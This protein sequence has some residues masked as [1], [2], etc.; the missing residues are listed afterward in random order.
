MANKNKSYQLSD[1]R[2]NAGV[3]QGLI[4]LP[5]KISSNGLTN[6][7]LINAFDIDWTGYKIGDEPI[8]YTGELIE[9]LQT[10]IANGQ[11]WDNT[12]DYI[13]FSIEVSIYKADDE[14]PEIIDIDDLNAYIEEQQN[15]NSNFDPETVFSTGYNGWVTSKQP[16]GNDGDD[17][18]QSSIVALYKYYTKQTETHDIG[19]IEFNAWSEPIATPIML[20][21]ENIGIQGN[22]KSTCFTRT[23]TDISN[24]TVTGGEYSNGLPNKTFDENDVELTGNNKITWED[25]IPNGEETL[26]SVTG[27]FLGADPNNPTW[28]NNGHPTRVMDSA[29]YDV[30]FAFEIEGHPNQVPDEPV[31]DQT[32]QYWNTNGSPNQIWYDPI[33]D[34]NHLP[35][36]KNWSDMVWRAEQITVNGVKGAWVITRIKGEEG[37]AGKK[38]NF[39]STVFT[40]TNDDISGYT[41]LGG[42]YNEPYPE[43]T[44]DGSDEVDI[45]WSDG[46]PSGT[47]ILWSTYHT[48]IVDDSNAIEWSAP[49]IV[50]DT[51]TYDV[52][53]SDKEE[54]GDPTNNPTNWYDPTDDLL[55]V[56]W[57]TMIW[58]AER[59]R[60]SQLDTWGP[61]VITRIKGENGI[62][63]QPS[64]Y[65]EQRWRNYPVGQT[66]SVPGNETV[67][68]IDTNNDWKLIQ[69]SP[70]A[71]NSM[72]MTTR[73]CEYY[74]PNGQSQW[75]P[76]YV[77]GSTW[78]AP[79]KVSGTD[80]QSNPIHP[81]LKYAWLPYRTWQQEW[82]TYLTTDNSSHELTA[83]DAS[84]NPIWNEQPGNPTTTNKYLWMVQGARY[85]GA[86]VEI[87][88][89]VYWTTPICLS[90]NDGQAGVDGS[91][92]EFIYH[93]TNSIINYT[94]VNDNTNP[95][96]WYNENVVFD[97]TQT[98]TNHASDY[99]MSG[100]GW[101]DNPTGISITN[102][103]EYA[104]YRQ[105]VTIGATK[106]W[107]P[108]CKPFAW[109]V[110]GETGLDGDG[111]EYIYATS[112]NINTKPTKPTCT[113]AEQFNASQTTFEWGVDSE[114]W[115]DDPQ[116]I[117]NTTET[118]Q[119]VSTRKF[120]T[121][122][123]TNYSQLCN[124][125]TL[126]QDNTIT[127]NGDALQDKDGHNLK[128]GMKAWFPYSTP[129]LWNWYV[130]D[131]TP[132]PEIVM[133]YTRTNS[134]T[135]APTKPTRSNGVTTLV[136]SSADG[137]A[138]NPG[139]AT[140]GHEFLW[141]SSN[142]YTSR[143]NNNGTITYSVTKTWADPICLTGE[144]G[145]EGVDGADIE[146][147]YF[148]TANDNAQNLFTGN[149][150]PS[151]WI[152]NENYQENDFPFIGTQNTNYYV[153]DGVKALTNQNHD[154][155]TDNPLGITNIYDYEYCSI[156]SKARNGDWG[157]FCPPFLWSKYGEQGIDGDGIEYIYYRSLDNNEVTFGVNDSINPVTWFNNGISSDY[158]TDDEYTPNNSH[159]TDDPTGVSHDY[160]YEYVS[161]RKFKTLTS[162]NINEVNLHVDNDNITL[163]NISNEESGYKLGD[164]MWFPYS[165]PA[166]WSKYADDAVAIN[167]TLESDNDMTAVSVTEEHIVRDAC[168]SQSVFTLYHNTSVVNV[169]NYSMSI[170]GSNSDTLFV[171]DTV[172]NQ[173]KLR[174]NDT[175][176]AA[177]TLDSNTHKYTLQINVPQNLDMS[178]IQ[179]ELRISVVATITN[180]SFD[181]TGNVSVGDE[182]PLTIKVKGLQLNLSD[183]YQLQLSKNALTLDANGDVQPIKIYLKS[184]T[185]NNRITSSTDALANKLYVFLEKHYINTD[186]SDN[187]ISGYHTVK[188]GTNVTPL[189]A[190]S[191]GQILTHTFQLYYDV[192]ETYKSDIQ[193]NL[194]GSV[195]SPV[196]VLLDEE[197]ISF[198]FDGVNGNAGTDSKSQEYVYRL[199]NDNNYTFTGNDN[200][201]NWYAATGNYQTD[202]YPFIGD[203]GANVISQSQWTDNPQSVSE[204]ARYEWVS[205]REYNTSTKKWGEFSEPTIWSTWS[206]DGVDGDGIEYIF[207]KFDASHPVTFY[208]ANNTHNPATWFNYN[209]NESSETEKY[210]TSEY[211]HSSE[212]SLW[213]DNA[214]DIADLQ[215]GE[216]I[217]VSIRKYRTIHDTNKSELTDFMS[218]TDYA[219]GDKIWFPYSTPKLWSKI[220]ESIQGN[221]GGSGV[222]VDFDNDNLQLAVNSDNTIKGDNITETGIHIYDDS[223]E[224]PITSVVIN[225]VSGDNTTYF[226]YSQWGTNGVNRYKSST[227]ST[228]VGN[229][230]FGYLYG[231]TTDN[232]TSYY[233]KIRT[234]D[235]FGNDDKI[236]LEEQGKRVQFKISYN[237]VDHFK[238]LTIS[239]LHYGIDGAPAETFELDVPK[240]IHYDTN[241]T[242][243]PS[244]IKGL[245]RHRKGGIEPVNETQQFNSSF[246]ISYTEGIKTSTGWQTPQTTTQGTSAIY[247][248]IPNDGSIAYVTWKLLDINHSNS[249]IDEE[250][251]YAVYDG[252]NGRDS[253]SDEYIYYLTTDEQSLWN[254]DVNPSQWTTYHGSNTDYN[255]KLIN[256]ITDFPFSVVGNQSYLG[257]TDNP[258]GV[259]G[260]N[261]V[262]YYAH[263]SYDYANNHWN[264]FDGPHIWSK[265]GKDGRDGDGV[266]YIFKLFDTETPTFS[267]DYMNPNTYVWFTNSKYQTAF[268]YT[269]TD[270]NTDTLWRDDPQSVSDGTKYQFVSTRRYRVLNETSYNAY[271]GNQ[272]NIKNYVKYEGDKLS[273]RKKA[274]STTWYEIAKKDDK[275]WFPYSAPSLWS[276]FGETGGQGI[277]GN[278]YEQRYAIVSGTGSPSAPSNSITVGVDDTTWKLT[279]TESSIPQGSRV[280]MTFRE[281]EYTSLTNK[282]YKTGS[283]WATPI[284]MTGLDGV[285]STITVDADNDV[286]TVKTLN[287][288]T[289]AKTW[290]YSYMYM[291]DNATPIS[292]TMTAPTGFTS[293]SNAANVNSFSSSA[294]FKDSNKYY[295]KTYINAD[296]N[297]SSDLTYSFTCKT[298][299]DGNEISRQGTI[300]VIGL[301]VPTIYEL[302]VT[303]NVVRLDPQGDLASNSSLTVKVSYIKD[304]VYKEITTISELNN[305]SL[306]W[307]VNN[308]PQTNSMSYNVS[309]KLATSPFVFDLKWK[310][311]SNK[312]V[313]MDSETVE[314]VSDGTIGVD[315]KSAEYIYYRSQ[316]AITSWSGNNDP[317]TWS[318]NTRYNEDDFPFVGAGG[319]NIITNC[320]WTDNPQGIDGSTYFYEYV[321]VREY[322]TTTKTWGAF[323]P[324]YP[325]STWGHSGLDGDGIEYIFL[326]SKIPINWSNSWD[327]GYSATGGYVPTNINDFNDIETNSS[328][329]VPAEI[330]PRNW[331][332][333]Y[334]NSV[335]QVTDFTGPTITVSTNT[336]GWNDNPNEVGNEYK[337]QYVSQRKYGKYNNNGEYVGS[338][339]TKQWGPFSKPKLWNEYIKGDDGSDAFV[340]EYTNDQVNIAVSS[341]HVIT[342]HN[343]IGEYS[344]TDIYGVERDNPTSL[345]IV[346]ENDNLVFSQNNIS[347]LVDDS[348]E[349]YETRFT[350]DENE[351]LRTALDM[352]NRYHIYI[353]YL[354]SNNRK[355]INITSIKMLY[356]CT[357]P[358]RGL[359]VYISAKV[360]NN[361]T[362]TDVDVVKA[363]KVCGQHIPSNGVNGN[364][365]I[366]YEIVPSCTAITY[367][368]GSTPSPSSIS[369]SVMRYNGNEITNLSS[370]SG[371]GLT[372]ESYLGHS[373]LQS[374]FDDKPHS[375][376]GSAANSYSYIQYNL[377]YDSTI[378]DC[379]TVPIVKNGVDGTGTQGF[380][381]S[382]VRYRGQFVSGG[383]YYNGVI[384]Q[385]ATTSPTIYYKDIV[386]ATDGKYY[387]P[388]DANTDYDTSG[389]FLNVCYVVQGAPPQSA[390]GGTNPTWKEATQFDF[391]A[392]RL[393]YADQALI[394]QISSHDFI[395]TK[396]D[397]YPVAGITT[398]HIDPTGN[399][400]DYSLLNSSNNSGAP[401]N[402]NEGENTNDAAVR[403]FAGE[404]WNGK[405]GNNSSY[406]L[407]YAPFNVRQDGTAYMT[408]AYVSGD[409][410]ANTL[411]L[412]NGSFAYIPANA[413]TSVTLPSLGDGTKTKSFYV[414]SSYTGST[415]NYI[416][417][418]TAKNSGD[419]INVSVGDTQ[420][421]N[422]GN[423]FDYWLFPKTN[424]FY[425][426]VSV[427][428]TWNIVIT[429]LKSVEAEYKLIDVTNDVTLLGWSVDSNSVS[430]WM[431]ADEY[432]ENHSN[433]STIGWGPRISW[434]GTNENVFE[435]YTYFNNT[436]DE[437][438]TGAM[439]NLGSLYWANLP[440]IIL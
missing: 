217:I 81:V 197:S 421:Q 408:N 18:W 314:K 140:T 385:G 299:K 418:G 355:Q 15:L 280:W 321:S 320:D 205:T 374:P 297:L 60:A 243:N 187:V 104:S 315:G 97:N 275:I 190:D 266:E 13:V 305:N 363:F 436:S 258:Q 189:K 433:S 58:R 413:T 67:I 178:T 3:E 5:A 122:T 30:E 112:D 366:V 435:F 80:G 144:P 14:Q 403:I 346:S 438:I 20:E 260:T 262:E 92:I 204:D 91:D 397:G 182:R 69:P 342:V 210:Q 163:L 371:T 17:V 100:M 365:A 167:L 221:P 308:Q 302:H 184:L 334:D 95:Q 313:L 96:N 131:G 439:C 93:L 179:D 192:D 242:P 292:F 89:G 249:V 429:D 28:T 384:R 358:E 201:K 99:I 344:G 168:S 281:V 257:W 340:V 154:T 202:D 141:M 114:T 364:N 78:T 118:H 162:T 10:A 404:I 87:D 254:N 230:I 360:H 220:G 101:T 84:N 56:D 181:T 174:S 375:I 199:T 34:L 273:Y 126:E 377:K 309:T 156:R 22:Y 381:G 255:G 48:F 38:G 76:R 391:V 193:N 180:A 367:T 416:R 354:L 117:N 428:N 215:E 229:N 356:A 337:Y 61:W 286:L 387:T 164:K 133:V 129:E 161:S 310:D 362:N 376:D 252:S 207:A 432:Y 146:F 431:D 155:W 277:P 33:E 317:T 143:E 222:V 24:Y 256:T 327:A 241:N 9:Q 396:S 47:E 349:S 289:V 138:D 169:S 98:G 326:L 74:I 42:T 347:F 185:S 325:L 324:P 105:T 218:Q 171:V 287:D 63:G 150:L 380:T 301:N 219:V 426:C 430:R 410:T 440:D 328:I 411:A 73:L 147:I 125:V 70:L 234:V 405:S 369:Y 106:Y 232:V 157:P 323:S 151:T 116:T 23:N 132:A 245:I 263:R 417:I 264:A 296:T 237:N 159:W 425:Q 25:G 285:A 437:D 175:V 123:S 206:V 160:K 341:E 35:Q 352:N 329:N 107:T 290:H 393:L 332:I 395:A 339:T 176:I 136:A 142:Y 424:A 335:Y 183:I 389:D 72:W 307:Y 26:W 211:I 109:S 388:T 6:Y 291:Y 270:G 36:G 148:R 209:D 348:N 236:P 172:N 294:Y 57:T 102:K 121:I 271:I 75:T 127:L 295:I 59:H 124:G 94:N 7:T 191:T 177:L 398:G 338:M 208:T 226:S 414:L 54:P 198:V 79:I 312:Y 227:D 37:Q 279:I 27:I 357:L 62:Q 71:N 88:T 40:R 65:Y 188:V 409:I 306:Y 401:S 46:I 1:E 268:E 212:T 284:P 378:I 265:Y 427:G 407:T 115:F 383:K 333:Y 39:K 165:Q 318:S 353:G 12:Q 283:T 272:D 186:L 21:T 31:K 231:T 119:W 392:T 303:P 83:E 32:S 311:A 247:C 415:A 170:Y 203:N 412:G 8:S 223:R 173:L 434:S 194:G 420:V 224:I 246:R 137:W 253:Y 423:S 196:G 166:L 422:S 103:Y 248:D 399:S 108:F 250:T 304:N 55:S 2:I 372:V 225:S 293:R 111:V 300:K 50:S 86:Y 402:I 214:K 4:T 130:N 343:I 11:P 216:G 113:T 406:S 382:I 134:G 368:R 336:I 152:S 128:I 41:V 373:G 379:E 350:T 228:T 244:S 145:R 53:F 319:A 110:Y 195:Q 82:N 400:K 43:E 361:T 331:I 19:D 251:T 49:T 390:T 29:G 85:N 90:G 370:L 64:N 394:N 149:N 259:D 51:P 139:T 269:Y 66:P 345:T 233:Y 288:K 267:N 120:T 276:S 16:Q 158:Q 240:I 238:T 386:L 298:I 200:P 261:K 330:D 239:G 135:Q 274:T 45:E 235:G 351:F 322:N 419:T 44:Y 359:D 77:E 316:N 282:Q 153:V 68:N 213:K 278:Y 52:E